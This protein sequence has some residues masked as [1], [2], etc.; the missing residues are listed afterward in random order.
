MMPQTWMLA[1]EGEVI[2]G[3][4]LTPFAEGLGALFAIYYNF[5]IAYQQEAACTLEF[6]QRYVKSSINYSALHIY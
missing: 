2:L 3:P 1:A 5:N 6:I 4:S